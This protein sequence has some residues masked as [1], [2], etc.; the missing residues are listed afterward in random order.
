M[1]YFAFDNRKINNLQ[2]MK[3]LFINTMLLLAASTV[4]A[5]I[6]NN[7][8]KKNEAAI[9]SYFT[10]SLAENRGTFNQNAAIDIDDIKQAR[11][12]V[13]SVWKKSVE[14]FDE[15]KLLPIEN[16]E[17][18]NSGKWTLPSSLEPNAIMPYYWGINTT[19]A[20]EGKLPMFLY[21]HGSGNKNQ[22]W[23]TGIRLALKNFYSP[24][25]YMVPQIPNTGEYYRW[26]I[27]SKQWAWE[28]LLRLAFLNDAI[29]ANRI[30]FFG[31]SEGGYGSQ[32]LAAFYA[33]YLAGA[34]PMAGGEPLQNAP[35]ENVANIAFSLRTGAK[36]YG[37]GR[38]ILTQKSLDVADSLAAAHPGYYNHYIE[39]IPERGHSI[40]YSPTTPWLAKFTRNPHPRYFYW[41]NY[42]MYGRNRE[43]FYNIKVN[44]NPSPTNSDRSCF[45]VSMENNTIDLKVNRVRYTTTFS[46]GGIP[47]FFDKE[48]FDATSG[49]VTLYLNEELFDLNKPIK[50]ILNGEEIFNGKVETNLRAM[51]ESCAVYYDPE[52]LFP[53]SIDIDIAS[54]SATPSSSKKIKKDK[55]RNK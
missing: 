46:L 24:G 5:Q 12:D 36:D 49:N 3:R 54:K 47:M 23:E 55:K 17:N 41:E 4:F 16:L 9:K 25:V 38:N 26:A 33:D 53:A 42:D 11:A 51:V 37:F 6:A 34:G 52:R 13:W 1:R 48:Y 30:Y 21:M 19:E 50:V 20:V 44:E 8:V 18:R 27:Q 7:K 45:E 31:I 22:E 29:D 35:M 10:S 40:D 43:G 39:L 15:E 14:E 2:N 28:K 32:R